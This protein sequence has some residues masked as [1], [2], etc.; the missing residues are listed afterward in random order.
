MGALLKSSGRQKARAVPGSI[1]G[2]GEAE[3]TSPLHGSKAAQTPSH[4]LDTPSP[5][6]DTAAPCAGS[7]WTLSPESRCCVN[8]MGPC[9]GDHDPQKILSRNYARKGDGNVVSF[10]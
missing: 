8:G 3:P 6:A 1:R 5:H 7:H 10:W 4:T 2:H 9:F